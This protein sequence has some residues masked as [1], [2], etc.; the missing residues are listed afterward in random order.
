M[1]VSAY[2]NNLQPA[3]F[4]PYVRNTELITQTLLTKQNCM[5]RHIK[6]FKD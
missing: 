4:D 6:V 1:I 2:T 5:M 3:K